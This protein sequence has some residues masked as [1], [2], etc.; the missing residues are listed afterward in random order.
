M[1]SWHRSFSQW[2][3]KSSKKQHRICQSVVRVG[4]EILED[5]LNPA[6]LAPWDTPREGGSELVLI[7]RDLLGRVPEEELA[8]ATVFSL[9]AGG[10]PTP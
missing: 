1:A 4:L 2:F 9:D 5:R 3:R 10:A 8:G 7:S 6:P